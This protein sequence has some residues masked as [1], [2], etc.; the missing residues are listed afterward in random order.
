MNAIR[1]HVICR[2]CHAQCGLI[3]DFDES[4][5]PIA[6]HGNKDNP[7]YAGYSCIRGR[8]LLNY[9]SFSTRLTRSLKRDSDGELAPIGWR[10]AARDVADKLSGIADQHGPESIAIYVGTFGYNTFPAQAFALAFMEAIRSP[11]IFTS[12][13]IDQPGKGIS[14]ALHGKWLA[15]GYRHPEWDGLMLVGTNPIISMN[16]GLGMNP[17]KNLHAALKRGMKLIVIDPRVTDVAKKAHIHL[18][19]RPGCD[20]AILACIARQIIEE[21]LYDKAFLREEVEGFSALKETLA[22]FTPDLVAELAGVPAEQ[23][24]EAARLYGSFKKA[25]I[26]C[27]TGANMSGFGNAAEYMSKVILTLI[28]HWRRAGELKRNVGVFIEGFPAIA[29]GTGSMPAWGFGT[30]LR[31]RGLEE[32]ISGLPTAAL[33]DEILTPGPGQIKALLVLGGNPMLAW[34]DQIKT[35]EAMQALDLL[36]CFDPRLSKTGQLADYVIAP[37]IHY[38]THGTTALNEFIGNFGGGWGYEEPYAQVCDP[39]LAPPEDSDLCEEFE[40]F[41]AMAGAM[42]LD[43]SVKTKAI[44]NPE[45]AEL[46][47]TVFPA[48]GPQPDPLE[49]WDATLNGAP[50]SHREVRNDP[51]AFEGKVL[52]R[53]AEIVAAK[54]EGWS[55]KL[56]I[57]HPAMLDELTEVAKQLGSDQGSSEFPYRLISRRL[58]EIHNSNWHESNLQRK[59]MPHH[60]A[61]MHPD[62]MLDV[63][64]TAGD[65]VK[66]ESARA[67][68]TCVAVEAADVRRGCLSVPHAWG[69]NPDENDDPLGAGGNTGRLSFNDRD[70]DKRSGIP[71][72]SAIPVKIER[73]SLS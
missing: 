10:D 33:A 67:A 65:I 29:A 46:H 42:N 13:T 50:V 32:S 5:H 26:S 12:V 68:I 15:G 4:G 14:G 63:G 44:I 58:K 43:L 64:I 55:T 62:D 11:M 6:T 9:H 73:A 56:N 19:C 25:D 71:I 35:Y 22:P 31:V 53:Q 8:E 66:I 28:G 41:H 57:G 70:F 69:V 3:V 21:D 27:G 51:E 40:F 23:L 24:V 17:A 48:G 49:A 54:P 39:I 34:P 20:A 37:K 38:E 52:G 59:R 45:K 30:K 36:V 72:M 16:G 2:S 18:Q 47:R 7:A 61:Y 60:P 1:K